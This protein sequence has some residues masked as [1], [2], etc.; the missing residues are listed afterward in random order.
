MWHGGCF[1]AGVDTELREGRR[2][3]G[4]L[5]TAARTVVGLVLL[6]S[7]TYGHLAGPFRPAP[8]VL[9]LVGF[10]GVLL[11]WQRWRSRRHPTRLEATGPVFQ[12]LNVS[13]FLAL[14]LTPNYAP[15]LEVTSD[16]AL[17]FYGVSMLLAA[18]RGYGGCEV[19]AVSNWLLGRD[20]Q[21]GC[22]LFAPLDYLERWRR[23][24]R[25]GGVSAWRADQGTSR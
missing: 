11:T 23:P 21:V 3:I 22:L 19:L 9:G 13:V 7:V 25:R 17:V 8:W 5:G 18:L 24:R 1:V 14:C 10:P 12:V 15:A 20:D 2:Q 6:G 16:G 4:P